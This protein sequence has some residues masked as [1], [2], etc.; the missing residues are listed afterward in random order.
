[1]TTRRWALL[2]ATPLALAS[3]AA[4]TA[5]VRAG[6]SAGAPVATQD[7]LCGQWATGSDQFSGTSDIDHPSG[8]SSMGKVYTYHGQTCEQAAKS[9]S[10]IGTYT[11][12]ISHSNV[13]AA[14]SGSSPQAEFGTEH[15]L[16]ALSTDS[17]QAAG[18]NGRI[19]NFD[20]SMNDS[21]GDACAASDGNNRTVYYAS[22]QRD[23]ANNC[24]PAGP[25][26]FNT[27]GGASTGAHFNGKYGSTVYQW[28]DM[29]S[30]SPCQTGSQNYCFEGVIV[31]FTN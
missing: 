24:S 18:F 30:M 26:N 1:M 8:S 16:A 31:G 17:N 21:D 2:A 6:S 29:T 25:G 7:L 23:T 10:S 12:T 9:D 27:H 13:H 20:L 5:A 14:E 19:T 4:G 15:G 3:L 28:G 11:W 22:G